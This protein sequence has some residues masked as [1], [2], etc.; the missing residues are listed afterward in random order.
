MEYN[1]LYRPKFYEFDNFNSLKAMLKK[2]ES[3]VI[4]S[5][6]EM[7]K[8][9]KTKAAKLLDVNIRTLHRKMN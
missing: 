3:D 4:Q 9:N 5:A 6:I 7:T 2:Y 1:E 8:G